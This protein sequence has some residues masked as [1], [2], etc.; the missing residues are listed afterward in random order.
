MKELLDNYLTHI[1][2]LG[3]NCRDLIF[4]KPA[5][6][7]DITDIE[8]SLT[9][10]I[11]DDFKNVL[12]TVSSHCEFKWFLPDDFPL[13]EQLRQIF[14]GELH[15]GLNFILQFNESKDGWIKKVFPDIDNEYDKVWH[16]KFVFQEVG[17]GD[18]IS[19]DLE[20]G[21]YGKIV[22]LSHDDGEG[23]GYIMANSF[24]ELLS[25][26]T[27]LGCVGGEDW[28]WLPFHKDQTT[29][30]DPNCENAKLWRNTIGL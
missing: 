8:K 11:P 23:H 2:K 5:T 24:S 25:N 20:P 17:N 4:E 22:Y 28:Q 14:S 1:D 7:S 29:G 10:Q 27:K 19:I 18:Y 16:N 13:P 30:I 12:L 15:W 6:I 3:G 21:N 9:Y 26:W